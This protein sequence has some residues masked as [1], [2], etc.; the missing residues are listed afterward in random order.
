MAFGGCENL[1]RVVLSSNLQVLKVN[2]FH[3][4]ISLEDV[5]LPN[6]LEIMESECFAYCSSL[7]ES[8]KFS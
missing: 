1:K 3:G 6:K 8:Q 2:L 5:T 4:C 7:L